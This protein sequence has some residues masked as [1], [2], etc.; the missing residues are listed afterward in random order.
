MARI[1]LTREQDRIEAIRLATQLVV[2]LPG[3]GAARCTG[4]NPDLF[5]LKS[6]ASK[7]PVAWQVCFVFH[8]PEAGIDG[9]ELFVA[10]DLETREAKLSE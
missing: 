9:G 2:E 6:K 5:A 8:P 1:R 4:A 7:I 3:L 10:V